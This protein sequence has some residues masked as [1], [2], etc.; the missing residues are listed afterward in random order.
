MRNVDIKQKYGVKEIET[1]LDLIHSR[2]MD[3][4]FKLDTKTAPD[5]SDLQDDDSDID[6]T[7]S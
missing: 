4:M 3:M 2:V 1:I 5:S 7:D 6:S